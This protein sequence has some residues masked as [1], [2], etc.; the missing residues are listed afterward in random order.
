MHI[1]EQVSVLVLCPPVSI[2]DHQEHCVVTLLECGL[3]GLLL[4]K[5]S[6]SCERKVQRMSVKERCRK[7]EGD[8]STRQ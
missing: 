6:I 4:L 1:G 5:C 3:P 7:V 2:Q 8:G